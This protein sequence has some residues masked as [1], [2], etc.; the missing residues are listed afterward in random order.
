MER[1]KFGKQIQQH[2]AANHK[3]NKQS[4]LLYKK[5]EDANK[6][7][8]FG[9]RLGL[10]SQ[11][12][13]DEMAQSFADLGSNAIEGRTVDK[14]EKQILSFNVRGIGSRVKKKEVGSLIRNHKVGY[15]LHTRDKDG[16][17]IRS[18]LQEILDPGN[19]G[20]AANGRAG[21]ILTIWNS[22]NFACS[23]F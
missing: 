7:W 9:K 11:R 15:M 20:W 21:G 22:D 23:S 13:D 4:K 16:E 5:M 10:V 12:S 17:S 3:G 1:L 19:F 8:D 18:K 2:L 14:G 6:A